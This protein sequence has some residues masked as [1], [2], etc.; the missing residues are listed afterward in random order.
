[1]G[2]T[3]P[4]PETYSLGTVSKL[5]GL[6]PEVLRAW[7]RR[8]A[9]VVP[10]RTDGGTRRYTAENLEKFLLAKEAVDR[11]HRIGKV[12][13]WSDEELRQRTAPEQVWPAVSLDNILDAG[14]RLDA[15]ECQRLLSI[16]FGS[17]GAQQF[18]R[19]V[20]VPLAH[21]IGD[22]WVREKYGIASEH[23]V[24][25]VLRSLLGAA[26]QPS[27]QSLLGP[28]IVFATPSQ[29]R[30]ELGLLVAALTALGSGA[31]A[32]YLGTDIP[33]GEIA[34]AVETA[35]ARA[36][37]LSLVTLSG[38]AANTAIAGIRQSVRPDVPIWVG[39]RAGRELTTPDGVE[40]V[41]T[42]NDLERRV[43][44]LTIAS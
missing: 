4:N 21:Q 33:A 42:L 37:G 13:K 3:R 30:H 43:A 15:S 35:K 10:L 31:N 36:L 40:Y 18:A 38:E 5:T 8:Y 25:S 24:T 29:E 22:L 6:S 44:L 34:K 17:L 23:L 9:L 2:L 27:A 39:G 32:I 11:G 12:S 16:H 1:M 20:A 14:R 41:G 28:R 26:I 7:E 19:E